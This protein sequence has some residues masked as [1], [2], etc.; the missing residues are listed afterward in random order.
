MN[1][2]GQTLESKNTQVQG[3]V[4]VCVSRKGICVTSSCHPHSSLPPKGKTTD[5]LLG[6]AESTRQVS[7]CE[8]LGVA[9]LSAAA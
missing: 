4:T 6:T 3:S 8:M 2:Q 5:C 1:G 9:S 7:T